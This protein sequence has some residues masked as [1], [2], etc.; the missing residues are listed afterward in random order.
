MKRFECLVLLATTVGVGCSTAD[1]DTDSYESEEGSTT[2]APTTTG[3]SQG[4]FG[5]TA[6]PTTTS[7]GG[8]A[9]RGG[10]TTS[11][12]SS[13][14]GEDD[15]GDN[16]GGGFRFDSGHGASTGEEQGCEKV[17]FLFIIDN[18]VSMEDNQNQLKAAFPG[19]M[20]A[21]EQNVQ[22]SDY[23]IMVVDTDDVTK[24][25]P[26]GGCHWNCSKGACVPTPCGAADGYACEAENFEACDM[27]LGAG[28]INPAGEKAS[29]QVCD[30]YGGNRYIINGEPDLAGTFECMASVGLSGS[31]MERPM[32]AMI[33]ALSNEL[34]QPGGCNDGFLREDAVLVITFIS[35]DPH[36]EDMGSAAEWKQAVVSAK[37]GNENAVVVVGLGPQAPECLNKPT[38]PEDA[39][40]HWKEFVESWG[41]H[42][43]WGTFCEPSYPEFFISAV[44][45]IEGACQDFEPPM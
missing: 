8:D 18:S 27:T 14:T 3:T 10:T 34:N 2:G 39:G 42:G 33:A 1:S 19:F 28:V 6:V 35:D 5:T 30:V 25:D 22:G 20:Q 26:S 40:T 36:M 4:P 37:L 44:D 15:G 7:D 31:Q 11:N 16:D 32:E 21:I 45:L 41:S 23:H 43:L 29:N 12:T 9:T 24:C 17:D 13:S 38:N